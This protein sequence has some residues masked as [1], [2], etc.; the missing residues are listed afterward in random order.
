MSG[1]GE[2]PAATPPAAPPRLRPASARAR[3]S[4]A[5]IAV[6]EAFS[7]GAAIDRDWMGWGALRVLSRQDWAPG[8]MR[9]DGRVANMERLFLVLEGA[10]DADG[11]AFGRHRVD[12]GGV[13]WI[14]SGHGVHSRL[15]HASPDA[16][17]RLVEL[18]LQPERVNA[19][20]G[21]AATLPEARAFD[22]CRGGAQGWSV[23]A[24][25][26]GG[27]AATGVSVTAE[28]ILDPAIS[29]AAGQPLPLPL[30]QQ[31]AVMVACL[32]PGRQ[33]DLPDPG[34][35]RWWLEILSGKTVV[36]D[37][38]ARAADTARV[39]L[40]SGDGLGWAGGPAGA[41]VSVAAAGDAPARLLLL[42]LPA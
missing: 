26:A 41:P 34:R 22:P 35:A 15:A 2:T 17:L 20:P 37:A 14:G 12:A 13:L 21:M 9:D 10:L 40:A 6:T 25:P 8:A 30:R 28:R 7:R 32:G 38:G 23:L 24:A 19:M 16:P 1:P 29:A 27:V 4:R 42:A 33:L 36:A 11:G 39:Q 31:A 3:A 5:G 18:W